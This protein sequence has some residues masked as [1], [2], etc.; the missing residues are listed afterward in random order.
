MNVPVHKLAA[1]VDAVVIGDATVAVAGF[2]DLDHAKPGDLVFVE[3]AADMDRALASPASVIAAGPFAHGRRADK[4]LVICDRPRLAFARMAAASASTRPEPPGVAPTAWVDPA[5]VVDVTA[6]IC[7]GAIVEAGARVGARCRIGARAILEPDVQMGEDC[8]IGPGV[9]IHTGT[10]LGNRVSVHAG[11]VLGGR[12]FG[13]VC[14]PSTGR[15]ERFPQLGTLLIE[16]DVEIGA[17]VTIDRGAFVATRIG[18]GTKIDN[19]VQIAHNVQIGA[20]VIIAAQVG[21]AGSAVIEDRV[22]LAGQVGVSD[23]VRIGAGVQVGGQSGVFRGKVLAGAG[24]VFWGTPARPLR[25]ALRRLAALG[26]LA[27]P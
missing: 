23:H 9:V 21:I 24:T 3:H 19:L 4:T 7:R 1:V 6:T 17:N 12:G 13:Y 10:C 22:V 11:S 2:S 5:A 20:H 18:R 26:H 25:T 14:D 15:H 16:D 27:K 8:D